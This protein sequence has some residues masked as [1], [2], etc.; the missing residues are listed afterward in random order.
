MLHL[1]IEAT[2]LLTNVLFVSEEYA[3]HFLV[4]ESDNCMEEE[5]DPGV[6]TVFRMLDSMLKSGQPCLQELT[7]TAI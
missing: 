6:S 3:F 4:V 2:W 5:Y 7:L 1:A